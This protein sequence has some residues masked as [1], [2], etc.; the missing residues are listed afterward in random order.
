MRMKKI[1]FIFSFLLIGSLVYSQGNLLEGIDDSISLKQP[2]TKT[3]MSSR[4]INAHSVEMIGR[5]EM[6]FRI[7]HRFGPVNQGIDQLFGLDQASMRMGFD[8]GLS[9]K[10][11]IGIGR[12]TFKKELDAFVKY[13]LAQQ[14]TGVKANPF[15]VVLVFG[16]SVYTYKNTDP[17]TKLTF[18]DRTGYYFQTIVG[19]KINNKFSLQ[20]SPTA[21]YRNMV[22]AG[23][24]K[25]IF[26]LG[27]GAR[28]KVSKRI[29][30]VADY[31]YV[32][33][34]LPQ[35]VGRNPLSL[36][37]D[38]ETGGHVFQLHFSNTPGM[39]ERSF[40]TETVNN[41]SKGEIQFGFNLS[42]MFNIKKRSNNR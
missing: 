23:D 21:V 20:L 13:R 36:G 24:D 15:S 11:T 28:Y 18:S 2:V 27:V 12:T 5:G 33:N 34:G 32:A 41:W 31:S 35:S 19:K 40:I 1:I 16:T 10:L 6:D 37:V 29:A 39:N 26:A 42:R 30:L 14:S 4:V 8:F 9:K 7:L 22:L 38:I 3:F 17:T 25:T